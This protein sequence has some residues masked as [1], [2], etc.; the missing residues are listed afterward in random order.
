MECILST[1]LATL[2]I[3]FILWTHEFVIR[4]HWESSAQANGKLCLAHSPEAF[5]NASITVTTTIILECFKHPAKI[6]HKKPP[7]VDGEKFLQ[8]RIIGR[9]LA[10]ERYYWHG[11]RVSSTRHDTRTCIM[12]LVLTYGHKSLYFY[13]IAYVTYL[14]HYKTQNTYAV[15]CR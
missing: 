15:R 14:L 12:R 2:H 9:S 1:P 6:K 10:W 4:M 8:L 13:S 11:R 7:K 5:T 3:K